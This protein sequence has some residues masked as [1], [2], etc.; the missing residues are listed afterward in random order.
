MLLFRDWLRSHADDRLLYEETKRMLAAQTWKYTQNYGDA[1][2]EVIQAILARA[3]RNH[4]QSL[5]PAVEVP[6]RAPMP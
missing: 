4:R 6:T 5:A 2:T 3:R 1:K